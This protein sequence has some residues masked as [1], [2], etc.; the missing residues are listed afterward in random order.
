MSTLD[1]TLKNMRG[2]RASPVPTAL[3]EWLRAHPQAWAGW[4]SYALLGYDQERALAARLAAA[5]C[6]RCYFLT[7]LETVSQCIAQLRQERR[8][9]LERRVARGAVDGL[10]RWT[11]I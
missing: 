7:G 5:G 11:G 2:R 6:P 1:P 3:R 4:P 9:K 8:Q 10:F